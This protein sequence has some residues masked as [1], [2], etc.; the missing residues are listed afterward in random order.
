[1]KKISIIFICFLSSHIYGNCLTSEPKISDYYESKQYSLRN[2]NFLNVE[3]NSLDEIREHAC[4]NN[5]SA[6][7]ILGYE[8]L[9]GIY[10][11]KDISKSIYWLER[12]I[13]NG[14]KEAN[15]YLGEIYSNANE[16]SYDLPK[17]ISHF[18]EAANGSKLSPL[19]LF[20]LGLIYQSNDIEFGG[21]SKAINYYKR[22]SDLGDISASYNLALIYQNNKKYK[23]IKISI[24]LYKLS[25]SGG[26]KRALNNLGT[27]FLT[28]DGYENLE[29]AYQLFKKSHDA[30][31]YYSAYYLGVMY[32]RG[33][34]V[35]MDKDKA[36]YFLLEARNNGVEAAAKVLAIIDLK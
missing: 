31:N 14:S 36:K 2:L 32:D 9:R 18:E 23:D 20:N 16:F 21:I 27:I 19:A 4:K 35:D 8:Y 26:H 5:S 6:E 11:E 24:E 34:F 1:M 29:L 22:S 13:K 12:A 25:I 10:L 30:G 28:E 33:L 7:L 17:A 3:F 15:I